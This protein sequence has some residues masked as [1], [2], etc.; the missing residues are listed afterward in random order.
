VQQATLPGL[1][2]DLAAAKEGVIKAL[3]LKQPWAEFVRR[4]DKRIETRGWRTAYRG[5]LAIHAAVT[6]RNPEHDM[7]DVPFDCAGWRII[8]T[9]ARMERDGDRV[10]LVTGAIVATCKLIDVVPMID[11]TEPRPAEGQYVVVP[12]VDH[13]YLIRPTAEGGI[14][15]VSAQ[16]PYGDYAPGRWAWLL[17]SIEPLTPA[18]EPPK[19]FHQ[20]LWTWEPVDA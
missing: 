19:G 13:A 9:L 20:G 8:P 16:V 2:R 12:D 17:G 10:G 11:P 14:L 15:D 6:L 3:T 5:P 1:L 18:I 7:R 4:G